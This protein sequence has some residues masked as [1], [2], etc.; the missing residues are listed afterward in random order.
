LSVRVEVSGLRIFGRH[1]VL[2]EERRDGQW[3]DVD[4]AV[5]PRE[6]PRADRIGEA[7]DYRE[8][9]ACV[10]EVVEGE[11]HR[12]LETLGAAIADTLLERFDIATARVGIG[13][14]EVVLVAEG[15]PRVVVERSR[16]D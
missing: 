1:G 15:R 3:F 7:I 16:P 8:I 5:E 12:L 11:P 13:K 4:V 10:R 9:A 14:P 2:E 6:P